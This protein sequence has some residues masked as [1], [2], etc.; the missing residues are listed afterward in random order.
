M[1]DQ[2]KGIALKDSL[3]LVGAHACFI[4][5]VVSLVEEHVSNYRACP[6][7]NCLG[8]RGS[9]EYLRSHVEQCSALCPHIGV[10]VLLQLR[11]ESEVCDF[12]GGEIGGVS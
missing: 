10:L 9:T 4:K 6:Y 5:W 7:V 12:D 1:P 3:E 8:I 11:G 2:R